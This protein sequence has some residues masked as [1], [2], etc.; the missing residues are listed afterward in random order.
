MSVTL[1]Q[2]TDDRRT[3]DKTLSGALAFS[4]VNIKRD[5]NILNPYIIITTQNNIFSYN[6]AYVSDFSRY[7]YID[8][9]DVLSGGRVGLSLKCDVLKSHA[10]E[11]KNLYGLMTRS[12]AVGAPT[13]VNDDRL[14]LYPDKTVKTIEFTGGNFNIKTATSSSRNYVLNVSG[15]GN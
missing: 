8:N 9:I 15:G 1:Y 4:T 13:Y 2:T 11:I 14:P 3:I 6:Y 10:T 7:Y 5:T 12:E